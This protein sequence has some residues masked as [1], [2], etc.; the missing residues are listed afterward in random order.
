MPGPTR[1]EGVVDFVAKLAKEGN[2]TVSQVEQE[3][4][5]TSRPSSLIRRFADP[6]EVAAMA[7]YLC[8]ERASAT[9]GG[10]IRVDGGTVNS[11]V[12]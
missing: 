1:T 5:K 3:F 7:V 4:F 10:A 9:T 6:D 2:K 8:S 12:P 11:I